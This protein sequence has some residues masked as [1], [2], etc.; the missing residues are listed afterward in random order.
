MIARQN[1]DGR[2]RVVKVIAQDIHAIPRRIADRYPDDETIMQLVDLNEETGGVL[3]GDPG[4]PAN[5]PH[6]ALRRQ[7]PSL[8]ELRV[9]AVRRELQPVGPQGESR[10]PG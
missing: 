6:A 8:V 5:L 2:F 1:C 7:R 10:R 9:R 3:R 4:L